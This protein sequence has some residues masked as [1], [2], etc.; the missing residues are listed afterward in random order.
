MNGFEL[1]KTI[2]DDPALRHK[3]FPFIFLTTTNNPDHVRKAYQL[4]A[5]GFFVKGQSYDELKDT[6]TSVIHY[7]QQCRLPL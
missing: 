3:S 4:H 2:Q 5:E 1:L 7:W 6:V